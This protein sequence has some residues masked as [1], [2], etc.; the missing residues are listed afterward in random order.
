ML[1]FLMSWRCRPPHPPQPFNLEVPLR[2]LLVLFSGFRPA[3]AAEAANTTAKDRREIQFV[4]GRESRQGV[5]Q[6][7]RSGSDRSRRL[8]SGATMSTEHATLNIFGGEML[9]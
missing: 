6:G 2:R 9:Q 4:S 5:R 8:Q 3:Q 1:F 7:G